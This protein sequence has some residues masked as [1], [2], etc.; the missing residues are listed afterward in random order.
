MSEINVMLYPW[1]WHWRFE[2]GEADCGI[3]AQVREGHAY[4]VFRCPRY[5]KQPEW[6]ALA[7]K[8]CA[9]HNAAL[10]TNKG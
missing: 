5:M 10:L 8:T 1:H 9:D 2:N 3:F 6:E 7:T 4:S